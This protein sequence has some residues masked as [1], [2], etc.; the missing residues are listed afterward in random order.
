MVLIDIHLGVHP[1]AHISCYCAL[2]VQPQQILG[3]GMERPCIYLDCFQSDQLRTRYT[4]P[5][6]G[7]LAMWTVEWGVVDVHFDVVFA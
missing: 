7:P 6:I 2:Q 3:Q 4:L 5:D 1:N